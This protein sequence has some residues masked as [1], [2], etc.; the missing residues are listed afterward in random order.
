[1][2][3]FPVAHVHLADNLVHI[4]HLC[5]SGWLIAFDIRQ[6]QVTEGMIQGWPAGFVEAHPGWV[7]R[8]PVP[9]SGEPSSQDATVSKFRGSAA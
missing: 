1:M 4:F 8:A 5:I 7:A 9:S 2:N 6:R 3:A